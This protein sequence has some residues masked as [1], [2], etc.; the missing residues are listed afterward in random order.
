M[1]AALNLS[2]IADLIRSGQETWDERWKELRDDFN[3][4]HKENVERR[5]HLMDRYAT[6]EG[7]VTVL[8]RDMRTVVGDNT[9]GSGLLHEIDKKVDNLQSEFAGI[10]KVLIFLGVLIPIVL[11]V[12]ALIYHR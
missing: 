3:E 2:N 8:E 6:L 1:P 12:L 4:K 7:R 5:H 9:G 10:K 11:G